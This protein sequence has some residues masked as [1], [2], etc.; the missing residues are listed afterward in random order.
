MT[1]EYN[2]DNNNIG[3]LLLIMIC[4][5]IQVVRSFHIRTCIFNYGVLLRTFNIGEYIKIILFTA[6]LWK[7][8]I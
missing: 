4:Y 2:N 3:T 7:R 8:V 6:T 5:Y 1:L